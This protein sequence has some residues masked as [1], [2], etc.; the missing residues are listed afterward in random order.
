MRISTNVQ[1]VLRG[2]NISDDELAMMLKNAAITSLRGFNRR[3]FHWLFKIKGDTLV[4]MQYADVREIG[5]GQ[6]RM[7]ED[8]ESCAGKGCHACGW[9]GQVGRWVTDK[10]L[11]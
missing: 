8:H 10:K 7:M 4:E 3:Y 2:E 9:V 1:R 6:T 5:K 11:P